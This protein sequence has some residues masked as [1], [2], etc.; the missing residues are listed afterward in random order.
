MNADLLK[1]A[2]RN[3]T[4]KKTRTALTAGMVVVGTA[5]LVI[6]LTWIDG[7]FGGMMDTATETSGHLR[8]VDP[9]YAARETL[10]P[11]Y[12]NVPDAQ[13]L[14]DAIRAVPGVE[15]V[16]PVISS[17]V[18]VTVGE[19]IGDVFGL[20]W[21]APR[22][23]FIERVG[24]EDKLVQGRFW[25]G[26]GELVLGQTLFERTGAKLGDD[27]VMLGMTQ[28]GSMSPI[29]GTLVGVVQG[30]NPLIDQR[31]FL[32]LAQM[33]WLTDIPGGA[34]EILVF[35]ESRHTA[36]ALAASLVDLPGLKDLSCQV[37][38][39]RD[40]WK[41]ML[42]MVRAIRGMLVFIV[43]FLAAMGV[44]NTMMM[45]VL[46]RTDEVGVLRAMG[47]TRLQTMGLFVG[48]ATAIA[49]AGG[50]LGIALGAWPGWLLETRGIT[51]GE[52]VVSRIGTELPLTATVYGDLNAQVLLTAFSLGVAM[53]ILGSALPA[54]RASLIQPVTAMRSGR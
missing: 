2:I 47:M 14:A 17:G 51:L 38:H 39:Q 45:S 15:G 21:G 54:L 5:L 48:E 19:E 25:Q 32:P 43:V 11:L 22:D 7:M 4:R 33:Q 13:T 30:G 9:D 52:D 26:E 12:E 29:K 42:P 36:D 10:M 18:T 24:V 20:A 3:T 31:V 27:V 46:E 50:F 8:I 41:D 40:I 35:G 16:A 53:A 37:W 23:F 44:W 6:C 1:L 34:I 49:V 28:D